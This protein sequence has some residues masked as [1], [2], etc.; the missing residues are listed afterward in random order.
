MDIWSTTPSFVRKLHRTMPTTCYTCSNSFFV[1]KHWP[2]KD[3]CLRNRLG[4]ARNVTIG[5]IGVHW[6]L[7]V[8]L[9]LSFSLGETRLMTSSHSNFC[10][11]FTRRLLVATVWTYKRKTVYSLY[12]GDLGPKDF[13]VK[14]GVAGHG[15]PLP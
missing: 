10:F 13:S 5:A 14:Q 4:T 15:N 1:S 8:L 6:L 11:L 7:P 9:L 12:S 3:K 2:Y